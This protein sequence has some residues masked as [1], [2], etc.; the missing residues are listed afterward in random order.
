ML[1]YDAF[2]QMKREAKTPDF[3]V[4][5]N[6]FR[7]SFQEWISIFK[8]ENIVQNYFRHSIVKRFLVLTVDIGVF[9]SLKNFS[10]VRI[11]Y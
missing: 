2:C 8:N 1:S 7:I 9:L 10:S 5:Q 4:T 6:I 3:S 11:S